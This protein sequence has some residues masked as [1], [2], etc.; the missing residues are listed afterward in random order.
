MNASH[1]NLS[2]LQQLGQLGLRIVAL[3][4]VAGCTLLGY[5][6][7]TLVADAGYGGAVWQVY[8][9]AAASAGSMFGM[10]PIVA[11]LVLPALITSGLALGAVYYMYK[12]T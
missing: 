10:H 1:Q 11:S 9:T 3:A 2:L 8:T 4:A 6:V 12:R 7:Y 5:G